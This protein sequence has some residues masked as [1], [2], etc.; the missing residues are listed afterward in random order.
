MTPP[1]ASF[2]PRDVSGAMR[3][4]FGGGGVF[5]RSILALLWRIQ[6][7]NSEY[8]YSGAGKFLRAVVVAIR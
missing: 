3:P 6:I 2:R 5:P 1:T 7:V 8:F 4:Q